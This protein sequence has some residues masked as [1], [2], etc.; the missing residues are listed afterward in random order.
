MKT[1]DDFSDAFDY[2]REAG[3]PVVVLVE[4]KRW[5]LYPSGRAVKMPITP[6]WSA[7]SRF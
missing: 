2:C 1:F 4:G 5:K 7:R 6:A 3:R